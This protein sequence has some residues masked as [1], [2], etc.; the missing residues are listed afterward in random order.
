MAIFISSPGEVERALD[1]LPP[2]ERSY[3][4]ADYAEALR[5]LGRVEEARQQMELALQEAADGGISVEILLPRAV[6]LGLS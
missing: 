4:R 1:L 2:G 6:G 5:R 3:A